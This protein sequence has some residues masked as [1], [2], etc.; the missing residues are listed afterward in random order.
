M[1][2]T[3]IAREK[4]VTRDL[5][6]LKTTKLPNLHSEL[7]ATFPAFFRSDFFALWKAGHAL[8]SRPSSSLYM[9]SSH[10]THLRPLLPD[11]TDCLPAGHFSTKMVQ[12][13]KRWVF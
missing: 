4:Y 2:N 9:S 7:V 10:A 8:H 1:N 13:V 12:G 5:K 3:R 11:F 6:M